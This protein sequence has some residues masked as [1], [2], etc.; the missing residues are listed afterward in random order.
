[1][2]HPEY[3]AYHFTFATFLEPIRL[4]AE[5]CAGICPCLIHLCALRV[6]E[7]DSAH[8]L[9]LAILR[10]SNALHIVCARLPDGQVW[11][12]W[13]ASTAY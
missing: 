7:V 6:I 5:A 2:H 11:N 4:S 3:V 1:M 13:E 12:Q 8:N 9:L 10:T